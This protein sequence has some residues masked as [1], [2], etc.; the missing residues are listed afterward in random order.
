ML[1]KMY[2]RMCLFV[3]MYVFVYV[4]IYIYEQACVH[5]IG[6]YTVHCT[7]SICIIH[8]QC[9]YYKYYTIYACLCLCNVYACKQNCFA[10]LHLNIFHK[11]KY[12]GH[13]F[14]DIFITFMI[15][16]LQFYFDIII[17][18][19]HRNTVIKMNRRNVCVCLCETLLCEKD[20]QKYGNSTR[21]RQQNG[22]DEENGKEW[23]Y[24]KLD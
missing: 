5:I 10:K 3:C 14:L 6:V 12:E 20:G 19:Q 23:K 16:A 17:F 9:I 15:P 4:Y 8:I 18:L 21:H 1:T 13:C 11:I 24:A 2:A 7:S 22:G